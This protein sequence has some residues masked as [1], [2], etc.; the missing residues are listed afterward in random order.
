MCKLSTP[1]AGWEGETEEQE[2]GPSWSG[3]GSSVPE[4][5]DP[6]LEKAEGE[7]RLLEVVL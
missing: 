1:K 2:A 6:D 7:K 5:R 3:V 4:T